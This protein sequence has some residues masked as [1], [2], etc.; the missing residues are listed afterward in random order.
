MHFPRNAVFTTLHGSPPWNASLRLH[1]V[2]ET[3]HE[4]FDQQSDNTALLG[5]LL[6]VKHYSSARSARATTRPHGGSS[7]T[8]RAFNQLKFYNN[9]VKYDRIFTFA[10]ANT[11]GKC[12]VI[13]TESVKESDV[14]LQHMRESSAIG[15][16]VAV[17][18]PESPQS[19]LNDM[20]VV[21]T[22]TPL[23]P[24]ERPHNFPF[25]PLIQTGPGQQRHF[26]LRG[27]TVLLNR[28]S[29][30]QASCKG[31]LC[32]RQQPPTRHAQCGCMF[33]GKTSAITMLCNVT[34]E[35]TDENGGVSR[36][37][38]NNFRSW[39]T[40]QLFI[41]P[42]TPTT[43][44]TS[45][46]SDKDGIRSI[47]AAS[48]QVAN[49][50]GGWNMIGWFRRGEVTDASANQEAGSEIGNLNQPIHISY[51]F[52]ASSEAVSLMESQRYPKPADSS[53]NTSTEETANAHARTET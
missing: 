13:I 53:A 9:N 14:L 50:G 10:D 3:E 39:R 30:E 51:L 37:T 43:D 52:P 22:I 1:A 46:F 8:G 47:V 41:K 15:D 4:D 7:S 35:Y 25:V 24:L 19:A 5:I 21:G 38:V 49:S 20:P 28:V 44:C 45:Y 48:L 27:I 42:I 33:A 17:I 11:P 31:I 26:I 16:F 23:L 18:E 6:S 40:S 29:I 12:F 34:F 32:D 2:H 36:H